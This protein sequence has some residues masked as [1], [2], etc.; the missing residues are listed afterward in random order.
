MRARVLEPLGL[1]AT[2]FDEPAGAARGHVQEGES[3][4]RAVPVDAYPAARRPSGGLWSSVADLVRFGEHHLAEPSTAARAARRRPRRTL[5]A[6]LVGSR[7]RRAHRARPRGV[8]RRLPVAAPARAGGA[9]RAR[10]AH[11]QLARQRPDPAASSPHSTSCLA[12]VQA[13]AVDAGGGGSLRARR[14]RGRDRR[15]RR[16]ARGDERGDRSG[17][18]RRASTMRYPRAAARRRRLRVRRRRPAA[19]PSARLP[20]PGR[21]ARRLDRRCRASRRESA[22]VAA[23]HPAT[24]RAGAEILADGGSAADAAVAA[25]LASCVAE[26]VMTGLLGGGHA[27]YY[28]AAPARARNL[29]CFCAVPGLGAPCARAGARP[30][31][32][33]LR[34]GA[35]PLRGRA[36][37]VRRAGRR[38]RARRAVGGVRPAAVARGSSSRRCGSRATASRC[39]PRTS[40]CL[41]MLEP[42]MTMREGAR[43]YAP[44]G[45]LLRDRRRARAARARRTR[46]SRSPTRARRGAYTGTIGR[47]APRALARARRARHRA[48]TST[49]TRRAGA[50]PSRRRGSAGASSRRGGL[51]G[52]PETLARLPR[53]ARA[54]AR[55]SASSPSSMRSTARRARDA[56]DEPRHGR[57]RRQRVRPDD[58]PRARL[59][60]LAPGPRPAPEQHAR[61]GRSAARARSSPATR[62]Q[63]MMAPTARPRRRR[64]R[65]R[66]RRGR[67]HAPAHRA[68]HRR[69]RRSS[70]R[71]STPQAAVERAARPPGRRAS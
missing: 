31:R 37:V 48:T 18:G 24:A 30:S 5:R 19:E 33:P 38:R 28:D 21:R 47:V 6:R 39:R 58:E 25:S 20:A 1:A 46:S 4:H 50:S 9:A 29:D 69:R 32:R 34:R 59:G 55:R 51:S 45:A 26:T 54:L 62:M 13:P 42:V 17:D 49:R 70:T 44:G 41:A 63:S 3:G 2:G 16:G 64:A 23:G 67:R 15:A 61:R 11:E 12:T 65:A 71:G 53:L 43:M 56:H 60:R 10:R 36:G 57:R 40:A 22:G 68:R 52:V 7:P 14:H 35:R 27:I 8:G 66:D